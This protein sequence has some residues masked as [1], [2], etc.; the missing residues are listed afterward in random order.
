M[1]REACVE[2]VA[3]ALTAVSLG[4]ERLELCARLELEGITP[5]LRFVREVL[6]TVKV[7][8]HVMV[9]PMPMRPVPTFIFTDQ[10]IQHMI[11]EIRQL[12]QVGVQGF[13]IGALN[14]DVSIN[15]VAVH[16]LM[17]EAPDYVFTFHKAIDRTLDPLLS[18][19]EL[20]QETKVDFVLTS[21]GQSSAAEGLKVLEQMIAVEASAKVIV[22][23]KVTHENLATLHQ[24]LKA[25]NYH[26][27][28]IVGNFAV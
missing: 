11:Y 21:G 5:S 19:I 28:S 8:V 24:N 20:Q 4:A 3:Q 27:R 26:G 15:Y 16:A 22:A 10:D 6:Q 23:G 14:R 13:V 12:K 1:I 2:T 25:S 9:S 18:F 7:P 17:Q